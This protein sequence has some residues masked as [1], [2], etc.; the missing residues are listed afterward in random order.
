MA[1]VHRIA[2][3]DMTEATWHAH[4]HTQPVSESI[5][6]HNNTQT[7]SFRATS[8][9]FHLPLCKSWNHMFS[10]AALGKKRTEPGGWRQYMR[11]SNTM[12]AS[13]SS[14]LGHQPGFSELGWTREP[15]GFPSDGG[16]EG[17]QSACNG[18]RTQI[19]SLGQEDPLEKG[20][21]IHS[22]ILP[23]EIPWTEEP[24]GLQSTKSQ[25]VGHN[26]SDLASMHAPGDPG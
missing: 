7:P 20:M 10:L 2:E 9:L 24:D 18:R 14:V 12:E 26:R 17:K 5:W 3:S 4:I 19:R 13:G 11:Y 1:T 23:W 15:E 21:A 22:S 8:H 16:P 6:F 25:R